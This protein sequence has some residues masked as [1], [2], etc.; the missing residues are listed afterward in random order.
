LSEPPGSFRRFASLSY[1]GEIVLIAL[2]YVVVARL[3]LLF[4]S[5]NPSA[6]PIW[7]PAGLALGIV[8]LRGYAVWPAILAGAVITNVLT[9]GS[10]ATSLAIGGGNTLETLVGA[11]ALNVWA[12][13]RRAFETPLGIAKFAAVVGLASTPISATIGVSSLAAAGFAKWSSFGAIWTTWW[14]GD[15][16]GCVVVAPVIVLW[17]DVVRPRR[18]FVAALDEMAPVAALAAVV[19]LVAYSP[20][21]RAL[22]ATAALAFLALMPLMW[23]ALR[24]SRRQTATAAMLLSGFAVWGV[25]ERAGPFEQ[26]TLNESLLLLITFMVS[27]TLPSLALSAAIEARSRALELSET[28]LAE[29]RE[30][31]LQSQKMEAI[32][33]LAGGIAHDFNNALAIVVGNLDLLQHRLTGEEAKTRSLAANALEGGRRAMALSQKLLAFSRHRSLAPRPTDI[34]ASIGETLRLL[35]GALGETTTIRTRLA[36]DLWQGVTDAA[37]LE[38]ALVNLAV[39]ARDAM[40]DGGELSVETSNAPASD[41]SDTGDCVAVVVRDNGIGM[42]EQTLSRAFEP[43]FTTKAAG[44]GTGLG[45]SQVRDF[46]ERSGGRIGLDSR[47]GQGTTVTLYLPR[48]ASAAPRPPA[49]PSAAAGAAGRPVSRAPVLVVEDDAAVR[50]FV[51]TALNEIGY[52]VLAAEGVRA[53]LELLGQRADIGLILTDVVMPGGDG[54]ALARAA[55]GVRPDMPI[56]FMT[57]YAPAGLE[58]GALV[59]TKPFTAAELAVKLR[60]AFG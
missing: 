44:K 37:G 23:A 18:R 60:E 56:V 42:D 49:E 22:H 53:G 58:D 34:N 11:A 46:V 31:L 48:A 21:T 15:L 50:E 25:L 28:H 24:G 20:V 29:T 45:L 17:A 19:G 51:C 54:P 39:N 3:S 12:D 5:I 57:G 1:A 6:S 30:Q 9:A 13:G 33:Q 10:L 40:P 27:V 52:S 47:E 38:S 43:F 55:R 16:A 26:I 35:A 32:G 7:P 2:V 59:L 8:L 4:A 41:G 36:A 14:L